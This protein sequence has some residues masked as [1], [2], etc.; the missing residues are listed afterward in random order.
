MGTLGLAMGVL[1]ALQGPPVMEGLF[2]QLRQGRKDPPPFLRDSQLTLRLRTYYF[3]RAKPDGTES[4]AL[5]FGG[6]LGYRSG[7]LLDTLQIGATFYGSAPLYAPADEDG[8]LLLKPGQ[9]ATPC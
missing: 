1:L 4:E 7:W 9:E 5:A 8:T 6:W 3:N 2:P